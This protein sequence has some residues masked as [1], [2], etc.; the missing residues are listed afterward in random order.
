MCYVLL[1]NKTYW[2]MTRECSPHEWIDSKV[3]SIVICHPLSVN[4]FFSFLFLITLLHYLFY[5]I[6]FF[7]I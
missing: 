3:V 4:I 6:Y 1:L 7:F 2:I 5:F